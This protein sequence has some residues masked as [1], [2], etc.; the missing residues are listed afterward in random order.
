[1]QNNKLHP[2]GKALSSVNSY[3]KFGNVLYNSYPPAN[4]KKIFTCVINHTERALTQFPINRY[5]PIIRPLWPLQYCCKSH[6]LGASKSG[7]KPYTET[8]SLSR[9]SRFSCG[10]AAT[11]K[12]LM[13]ACHRPIITSRSLTVSHL[14]TADDDDKNA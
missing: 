9:Y 13:N 3:A 10:L 5:P 8:C 2:R 14:I 1:M 11:R 12:T 7:C 4:L 6:I